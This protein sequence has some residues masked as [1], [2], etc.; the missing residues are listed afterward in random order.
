M[1]IARN[2]G[3]STWEEFGMTEDSKLTFTLSEKG[4]Y[5]DIQELSALQY[6]DEREDFDADVIFANFREV[7]GG[8]LREEIRRIEDYIR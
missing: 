4:K 8:E 3:A 6:S 7:R 1:I 2:Y 5:A